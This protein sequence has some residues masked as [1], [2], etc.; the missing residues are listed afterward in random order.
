MTPATGSSSLR[1]AWLLAALL[2]SP[3][4]CAAYRESGLPPCASF[5]HESSER[6][7]E[8]LIEDD[9]ADRLARLPVECAVVGFDAVALARRLFDA[10]PAWPV[11]I[12]RCELERVAE[13]MRPATLRWGAHS[14]ESGVPAEY[15]AREVWRWLPSPAES[16]VAA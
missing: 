11:H 4:A 14:L 6:I 2:A 1:E 8:A 3:E 13:F 10:D 12:V 16:A 7:A 9:S 15:V 5:V